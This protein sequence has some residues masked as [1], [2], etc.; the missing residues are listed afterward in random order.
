MQQRIGT[1]RNK[2]LS[3]HLRSKNFLR[4]ELSDLG[5]DLEKRSE[6]MANDTAIYRSSRTQH[7]VFLKISE[8]L[9]QS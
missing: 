2:L 3:G 4:R 6:I 1:H 7:A 5:S 9:F 8:A